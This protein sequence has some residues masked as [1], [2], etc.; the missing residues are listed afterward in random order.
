MDI[1]F[2][3]PFDTMPFYRMWNMIVSNYDCR[4]LYM[5]SLNIS[6][7]CGREIIKQKIPQLHEM[8]EYCSLELF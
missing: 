5:Y 6:A 3:I 4:V 1:N 8:G 2:S 7:F